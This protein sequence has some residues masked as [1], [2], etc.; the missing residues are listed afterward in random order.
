MP[1]HERDG[2]PLLLRERQEL[3]G[4]LAHNVAV[5]PYIVGDPETIEDREQHQWVFGRFS[6]RLRSLYVQACL[7]ERSLSRRRRM[8]FGVHQGVRKRD[9]K[10]DL[11][12]TQCSRCGQGRNLS[13]RTVQLSRRLD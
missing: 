8:A 4:E 9:L 13:K 6:E 12:A 5:E 11:L 3:R 1:D 10:L 7:I 2:R